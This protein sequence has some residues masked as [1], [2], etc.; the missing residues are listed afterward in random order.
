MRTASYILVLLFL[1]FIVPLPVEAIGISPAGATYEFEPNR[2]LEF[3]FDVLN[4]EELDMVVVLSASSNEVAEEN[5]E[6]LDKELEFSSSDGRKTAKAEV[7]LPEQMP[8]G[9]NTVDIVA[10]QKSIGREGTVT[11]TPS[12]TARLYINVPTPGT[13]AEAILKATRTDIETPVVFST[14]VYNA[15]SDEISRAYTELSIYDRN[16]E[17]DILTSEYTSIEPGRE[18]KVDSDWDAPLKGKYSVEGKLLYDG[19][20]KSL[21][22]DFEVGTHTVEVKDIFVEDYQFGSIVNVE[23][24]VFNDWNRNI[25]N[26]YAYV[27]VL[28]VEGNV[29]YDFDTSTISLP[30]QESD[31]MDLYW[32]TSNLEEGSYTLKL[33]FDID[34]KEHVVEQD[35]YLSIDDLEFESGPHEGRVVEETAGVGQYTLLI[36]LLLVVIGINVA[37]FYYIRKNIKNK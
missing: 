23:M 1:I 25:D 15:G 35:V 4:N 3:D 9:R 33:N 19:E 20:E 8:P 16:E 31:V 14:S 34:G 2:T 7:E 5:I 36:L 12:V 13:Y 22:Q 32:D 18:I 10:R 28:D 26:L 29:V 6:L 24:E 30:S 17:L 11:A 37:M 21:S 27:E